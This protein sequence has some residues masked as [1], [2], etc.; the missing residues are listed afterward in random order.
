MTPPKVKGALRE[1]KKDTGVRI[2]VRETPK[3]NK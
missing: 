1:L 2:K 3:T